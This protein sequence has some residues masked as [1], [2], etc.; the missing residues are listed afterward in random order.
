MTGFRTFVLV[1]MVCIVIGLVI[2]KV[3]GCSVQDVTGCTHN[4]DRN[5]WDCPEEK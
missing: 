3:P 1:A 4:L 2:A 5:E